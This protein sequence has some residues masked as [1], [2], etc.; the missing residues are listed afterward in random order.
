MRW[1]IICLIATANIALAQQT[2]DGKCN[3]QLGPNS[4]D[5]NI[6]IICPPDLSFGGLSLFGGKVSSVEFE[7][8]S[9]GLQRGTRDFELIIKN[10]TE[11]AIVDLEL[12]W[13]TMIDDNGQIYSIDV[14]EMQWMDRAFRA[15]LLPDR[16]VRFPIRLK[17]PI[18]LD[19]TEIYMTL[20]N[21]RFQIRGAT[22]PF[23]APLPPI[24]WSAKLVT[25]P[26]LDD[27][28]ADRIAQTRAVQAELGRLGYY[29]LPIDGQWGQGS[30]NALRALQRDLEEDATG[31]IEDGIRLLPMM[32]Q[33]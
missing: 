20:D 11:N 31:R 19:A 4:N 27:A 32:R 24:E 30:A 21:A 3:V 6:T 15:Q 14:I 7:L 18:A 8:Q 23:Q 10:T 2:I 13:L 29:N 25:A 9:Q 22:L 33:R 12:S 1:F 26:V 28:L 5:N 17:Q 16:P